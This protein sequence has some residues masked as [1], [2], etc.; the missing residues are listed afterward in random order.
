MPCYLALYVVEVLLVAALKWLV[1]GNY[2]RIAQDHPFYSV[3]HY[4][5]ALMMLLNSAVRNFVEELGG[6]ACILL[7][8]RVENGLF[9]FLILSLS[10]D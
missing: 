1:V 3:Y 8:I 7:Y 9:F 2:A 10:C 6:S 5:W 4:K